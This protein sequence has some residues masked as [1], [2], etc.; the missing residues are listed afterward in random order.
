MS[1]GNRPQEGT[2]ERKYYAAMKWQ[3][4]QDRIRERKADEANRLAWEAHHAACA[5]TTRDRFVS[6]H[7]LMH[8]LANT[9]KNRDIVAK[10]ND[11]VTMTEVAR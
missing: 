3:E 8:G 1:W 4:N 9:K 10:Q 6:R 7:D 2:Q 11:D 5:A